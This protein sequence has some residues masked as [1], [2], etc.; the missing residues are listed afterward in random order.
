MPQLSVYA[1]VVL[2]SPFVSVLVVKRKKKV[3][4]GVVGRGAV[5]RGAVGRGA[6]CGGVEGEGS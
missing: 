4:R 1:L 5:G 2:H 3:G 6:V